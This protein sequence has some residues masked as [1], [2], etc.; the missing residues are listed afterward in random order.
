MQVYQCKDDRWVQLLGLEV[1]K[2]WDKTMAALGIPGK[3]KLSAETDFKAAREEATAI[4]KQK[5]Y[6][7]WHEIFDAAD[8]WHSPVNRF[9]DL[10]DDV[11]ANAIG[12]FQTAP[13]VRHKLVG[14]PVKLSSQAGKDGPQGP[15]P[16]FGE[17]TGVVLA[18]LGYSPEETDR[19][20]RERIVR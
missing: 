13:G 10:P 15:A 18:D 2:H 17:H 12:S 9:E 4:I 19:L 6:A 14:N 1:H 3:I 20:K 16:A 11:Q 7:E 5:T 8:V